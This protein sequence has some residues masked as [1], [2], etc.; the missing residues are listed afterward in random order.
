MRLMVPVL[1]AV[2]WLGTLTAAE[3]NDPPRRVNVYLQPGVDAAVAIRRLGEVGLGVDSASRGGRLS[4]RIAESKIKSLSE[5]DLVRRVAVGPTAAE[6][7]AQTPQRYKARVRYFIDADRNRHALEFRR[8]VAAM[9]A[10]GFAKDPGLE[11]E[12]LYDDPISGTLPASEVSRF[13]AVPYLQTVLLIPEGHMLP[14]ADQPVLVELTLTSRLGP[15]RQQELYGKTQAML[16]PLGWIAAPGFDHRNFTRMLGWLPSQH[17][18]SV[19]LGSTTRDPQARRNLLVDVPLVSRYDPFAAEGWILVASEI[20]FQPLEAREALVEKLARLGFE[21]ASDEELREGLT[22]I[23]RGRLPTR[24]VERVRNLPEVQ[25]VDVDRKDAVERLASILAVRVVP[26]PEG[27]EPPSTLPAEQPSPVTK[28]SVD[29]RKLLADLGEASE[30]PVRVEVILRETP[31]DYETRWQNALDELQGLVAIDGRIGPLIC[32]TVLPAN[33]QAVASRPE[34]STIR[35]PQMPWTVAAEIGNAEE[36]SLS[37]VE[38][39]PLFRQPAQAQPLAA[40][41]RRRSPSRM[42]VVD[43]DFSGYAPLVGQRLPANTRLLDFTGERNP[44]IRPEPAPEGT[45]I[46]SGTRLALALASEGAEELLLVRIAPDGPYMLEQVARAIQ[47]RGW[48]SEAT[49]RRETELRLE[50]RRLQRERAEL[51]VRRRLILNDFRDDEESKAALQALLKDER[52][53]ESREK[54]FKERQG[55]F[56]QLVSQAEHLRGVD[57]VL[58]GPLWLNGQPNLPELASRQRY[59]AEHRSRSQDRLPDI[60]WIQAVPRHPE[61]SWQGLFRDVDRDEAME[62]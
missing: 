1:G 34:V 10:A 22:G 58:I 27:S 29:L 42:A 18:E 12:E 33:L 14:P 23:L 44:D 59:L 4:G 60:A 6:P 16:R 32:G 24:V 21:S 20:R 2:L 31:N 55:R 30:R 53:L 51:R 57:T 35:L 52:N 50:D 9:Q 38:F 48:R 36:S 45:A 41:I 15:S 5:S 56:V 26:E 54:A 7:M 62:F 61:S 28:L 37:H 49:V 13:L 3:D 43:V 39:V 47:G 17:L 8:M 40:L 19:L 46:G 25:S 11:Q